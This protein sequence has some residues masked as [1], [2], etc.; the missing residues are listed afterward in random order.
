MS[1][2]IRR[3]SLVLVSTLIIMGASGRGGSGES[4]ES[5]DGRWWSSAD[6]RE[7][8]GFIGGSGDCNSF[9]LHGKVRYSKSVKEEQDLVTRFYTE[10]LS[11]ANIGVFDIL[12]RFDN[13]PSQINRT[14]GEAWNEP[15]GYYDGQYWREADAKERQG[16]VEGYLWC[17]RQKA[18]NPRG[19]F[20]KST[21]EYVA[22]ISAWYKLNEE[23]GDVDP[24]RVDTKI[25]DVLFKFRDHLQRPR[26]AKR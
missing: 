2:G 9:E 13:Q 26:S 11:R 7:Q 8:Y 6:P 21:S 19:T 12:R 25:A 20:S 17:Y 23:T 18:H 4:K 16:F 5:Y 15:H 22:L 10:D 14:G 24:A 1:G 3:A